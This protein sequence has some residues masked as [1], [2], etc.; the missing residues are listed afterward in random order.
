MKWRGK[1][2]LVFADG[3]MA[4]SGS[5]QFYGTNIESVR[6]RYGGWVVTKCIRHAYA[7]YKKIPIYHRQMDVHDGATRKCFMRGKDRYPQ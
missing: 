4:P 3:L 1:R 2:Y 7:Q 6:T 5:H